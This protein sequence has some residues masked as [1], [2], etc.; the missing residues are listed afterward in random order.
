MALRRAHW[1]RALR[2]GGAVIIFVAVMYLEYDQ[3]YNPNTNYYKCMAH[4]TLYDN[5]LKKYKTDSYYCGK[6]LGQIV[7]LALETGGLVIGAKM[8]TYAIER[9]AYARTLAAEVYVADSTVPI[10]KTSNKEIVGDEVFDITTQTGITNATAAET[11]EITKIVQKV[12][13]NISIEEAENIAQDKV[14]LTLVKRTPQQL[15][16]GKALETRL[17]QIFKNV[18]SAEFKSLANSMNVT[19]DFLASLQSLEQ[20]QV[21]LPR[22]GWVVLDNVWVRT[23]KDEI[24]NVKTFDLYINET[25]LN[26]TTALSERQTQ[27]LDALRAGTTQFTTRSAI[28]RITDVILQ[29][30]IVNIKSFV[31]TSSDG[32]VNGVLLTTKLY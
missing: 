9:Y 11:R 24:T 17:T 20:L 10:I 12:L 32:T 15:I 30:Y 1:K 5:D 8:T 21:F 26:L 23:I 19:P 29:N 22:E 27:F 16:D 2:T 14:L 3:L 25:K 6:L 28:K 31:K 18:D 7:S 4:T 13:P